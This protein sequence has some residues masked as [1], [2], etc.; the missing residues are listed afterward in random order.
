M[1]MLMWTEKEKGGKG[2]NDNPLGSNMV[3]NSYHIHSLFNFSFC[4]IFISYFLSVHKL[5]WH[6]H[7]NSAIV[8]KQCYD[9][10]IPKLKT[11]MS[12]I[13]RN[14]SINELNI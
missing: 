7:N 9:D 14:G 3:I 13:G 2:E 4:L 11:N 8:I 10:N 12:L 6:Y 1:H 5:S